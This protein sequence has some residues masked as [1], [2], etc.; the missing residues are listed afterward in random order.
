[1]NGGKVSP[2]AL[3]VAVVAVLT[4]WG[5]E[6]AVAAPKRKAAPAA[7]LCKPD[8]EIITLCHP[9]SLVFALCG[10]DRPD[11]RYV[12]YREKRGAGPVVQFPEDAARYLDEFRLSHIGASGFETRI[13]FTRGGA[14]H[15]VVDAMWKGGPEFDKHGWPVNAIA[16]IIREAG[17][18]RQYNC[19]WSDE[20]SI[21]RLGYELIPEEAF[22][23]SLP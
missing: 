6:S 17:R 22:D 2:I 23:E 9:K 19:P 1:M 13:R 11:K 18:T 16:L 3:V 5:P 20:A 14:E 8:E 4:S 10:V 15:Y 12:V 21:R 7:N